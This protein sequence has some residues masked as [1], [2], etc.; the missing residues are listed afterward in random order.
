MVLLWS[1]SIPIPSWHKT[2]VPLRSAVAVTVAVD[3]IILDPVITSVTVNWNGGWSETTL[4][5]SRGRRDWKIPSDAMFHWWPREGIVQVNVTLSPGHNLSTLDCNWTPET[6]SKQCCCSDNNTLATKLAFSS[7]CCDSDLYDSVCWYI[8]FI[9][10][11]LLWMVIYR[12]L[13]N[14]RR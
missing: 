5:W 13:G 7:D 2:M 11:P 12:R 8:L 1:G 14:F 3:V 4:P 9:N 6:E 10:L